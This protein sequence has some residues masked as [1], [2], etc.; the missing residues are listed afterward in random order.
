[1]TT[2]VDLAVDGNHAI[3]APVLVPL[4]TA[5]I[6]LA[7]RRHGRL[8][9]AVSLVGVC[10][11]A[12]AVAVLGIV[13]W[14][15]G[16]APYQLSAWPAPFGISL[17]GDAL[18]AF[19]LGIAAAVAVPTLAYAALSV[20]D[21]G[22][23]IAFHTL[24]HFLLAG[25]SGAFLTGDVFN[26]FVW[27][28]VML[29]PSYALVAHYGGGEH[30][31]AALK[32]TVL[33]LV[34]SAVMLLGVG[35]L[36]AT[37]GTL[38]MAD[39]AHRLANAER[40]GVDPAAT[41]VVGMILISVF[42]LKAGLVPFQFWV[43]DA[44]AAA[45][46][47][48][49]ALLAGVTKKVGLYAIARL[50][51]TVFAAGT[52]GS[53]TPFL[54]IIGPALFLMAAASILL[55]GIGAVDRDTVDGVLA[56]SSISQAGF[57][58]LPLAIAATAPSTTIRTLGVA[59]A[60]VYALNHSLAKAT[61]FLIAGVLRDRVGSDA[62]EA[63]GGL[64]SRSPSLSAAFLIGALA[65][66]GIPPLVGFFGKLFVFDTAG[67]TFA[68]GGAGGST[69]LAVALIGAT[70]SIAY[71]TRAWNRGFWGEASPAVVDA[72]WPTG[73]I[74]IIAVLALAI[75]GVGI[76]F[77][78]IVRAAQAGAEAAVSADGR[79]VDAVLGV[80]G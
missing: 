77:D 4:V 39:M 23:R 66:V 46:A 16:V 2:G 53:G 24:V 30:L 44:Y 7:V 65:L 10:G 80:S 48:V 58:A 56:Y 38:N 74:G 50:T 12:A 68:A 51:F 22:Q 31:D 49:T 25:V 35:G 36:Y 45:P 40:Y 67:Q 78:P 29:L 13:V 60:L 62:F 43:P 63:L 3:V 15:T 42:A 32:Y 26:L 33:N 69:A 64:A 28:E 73:R 14:Q 17:V 41:L 71:V 54:A 55:G 47:P 27:F 70:L 59:A 37:T 20:G 9:R 75:I 6:T 57:I 5:I 52:L 1:M 34:G 8:Q 76:G 21:A 72:S 19:M 18:S 61:L 79:Y 11:Y